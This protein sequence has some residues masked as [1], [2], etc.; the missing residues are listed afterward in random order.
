M[1]KFSV[2]FCLIAMLAFAAN[3]GA[4]SFN[5]TDFSYGNGGYTSSN[6]NAIVETFDST[7]KW[8]LSG[9]YGIAT[10]TSTTAAAPWWVNQSNVGAHDATNYLT[11]PENMNNGNSATISF[12]GTY[13][14][15]SLW[16]GS[17]DVYNKLTFYN[18]TT[19]VAE[20]TG[21]DLLMAIH[22]WTSEYTN[23]HDGAQESSDTNMYVNILG[24]GNFDSVKL[25]STSYAFECDNIAVANVPE[26]TTMLLLGFGLVGLAGAGRKFKK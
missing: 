16:W 12:G 4:Y 18:G 20:I 13:N 15:L 2:I 19:Q 5:V 3:A 9:S 22:G 21:A 8:I 25:T 17:I 14:S 26:P 7:Q 10:G 1:K 24:L 23:D 6:T 11:V